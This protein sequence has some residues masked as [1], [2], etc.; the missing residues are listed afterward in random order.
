MRTRHLFL[1]L[2]LVAAIG[3][4]RD[5]S[6]SP[7]RA[8]ATGTGSV[9][10]TVYNDANNN[11]RHDAD[12]GLAAD[13][14]VDL[15]AVTSSGQNVVITNHITSDGKDGREPYCF[16]NLVPRQYTLSISSPFYVATSLTTYT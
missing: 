12:E 10:V 7:T 4:R 13:V 3:T 14:N 2:T 6:A 5:A 9:C 8:Q 11:N 1:L 16:T 15:M